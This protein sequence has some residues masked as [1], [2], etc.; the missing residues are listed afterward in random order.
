MAINIS[1]TG[2]DFAIA[3][4]GTHTAICNMV[5]D[6]GKQETKSFGFKPQ[7]Y[8]RFE[9]PAER[10]TYTVDDV[11]KEG[12]LSI[13][14]FYTAS[15]NEKA[16][17]RLHLEGWRGRAFTGA[18]LEGFDISQ[19]LGKSCLLNITHNESNNKTYANIKAI[20]SMPKG[21]PVMQ[22]ENPLVVYGPDD[23]AGWGSLPE[24]LQKKITPPESA[25]AAAKETAVEF[26]DDIPF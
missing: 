9:I 22:A 10:I 21:A 17:L 19:V 7:V 3:P 25:A 4:Q 23:L 13:G 16:N 20:V 1:E 14:N 11:E 24:W 6:M 2:G 26:D 8:L 15:L 5:V 12:P 18:E